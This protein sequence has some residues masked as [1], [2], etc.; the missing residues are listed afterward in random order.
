M[1]RPMTRPIKDG[2]RT[3]SL[4]PSLYPSHDP[5]YE[6][7]GENLPFSTIFRDRLPTR[8]GPRPFFQVKPIIFFQFRRDPSFGPSHDPSFFT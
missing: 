3:P 8:P 7:S 5:S 4:Y 2:V 1:T 6:I